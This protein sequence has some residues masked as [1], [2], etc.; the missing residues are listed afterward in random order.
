MIRSL[1]AVWEWMEWN[2]LNINI[3]SFFIIVKSPTYLVL[4]SKVGLSA[5]PGKNIENIREVVKALRISKIESRL[6]DDPEVKKYIHNREYEKIVVEPTSEI[7]SVTVLFGKLLGP[8][9]EDLRKRNGIR[10]F[11][12]SNSTIT[13]YNVLMAMKELNQSGNHS[14]NTRFS[15]IQSLLRGREGLKMQE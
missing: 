4:I 7:N 10:N 14:L 12:G 15:V 9:L 13:S 11:R 8:L 6:D 1:C 2:W 5:T 3:S